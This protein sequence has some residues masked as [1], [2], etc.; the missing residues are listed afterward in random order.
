MKSDNFTFMYGQEVDAL[1]DWK[2]SGEEANKVAK[3]VQEVDVE[4][5]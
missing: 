4:D 1:V 5:E 2:I 3:E